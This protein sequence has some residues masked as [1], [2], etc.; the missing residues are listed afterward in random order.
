[1]TRDDA[2]RRVPRFPGPAADLI[3]FLLWVLCLVM[4]GV[5]LYNQFVTFRL[6]D[7]TIAMQQHILETHRHMIDAYDQALSDC[8][9]RLG[10]R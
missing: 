2:T 8:R 9:G 6:M 7:Q 10:T 3:R 4:L 5:S 1:M